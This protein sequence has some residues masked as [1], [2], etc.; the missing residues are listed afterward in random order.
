MILVV[1]QTYYVLQVA[2]LS[3]LHVEP[4]HVYFQHDRST[5][6]QN[7]QNKIQNRAWK[8]SWERVVEECCC[9]Q[10]FQIKKHATGEC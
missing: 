8:M 4:V 6:I 5:V 9:L 2:I 1:Y 7:L 3:K 10:W